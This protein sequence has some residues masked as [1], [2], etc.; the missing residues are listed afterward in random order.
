MLIIPSLKKEKHMDKN[1]TVLK[2]GEYDYLTNSAT[3]MDCTGLMNRPPQNDAERAAY[4]QV[5]QYLP[6]DLNTGEKESETK[7]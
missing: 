2:K 6:P 3:G 1:K 7:K 4:Q 5:Y